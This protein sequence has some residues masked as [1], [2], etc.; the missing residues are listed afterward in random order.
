MHRLL[1]FHSHLPIHYTGS[2]LR[3]RNNK[4]RTATV[5]MCPETFLYRLL[6]LREEPGT[7]KRRPNSQRLPVDIS[8]MAMHSGN[9]IHRSSPSVKQTRGETLLKLK[10]IGL[11][12]KPIAMS[13]LGNNK[14]QKQKTFFRLLNLFSIL[15]PSELLSDNR[16]NTLS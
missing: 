5:K 7:P 14:I 10:C 9:I 1:D 11:F 4:N 12:D 13:S 16:L 8:W 3:R 2:R 15:F 6:K